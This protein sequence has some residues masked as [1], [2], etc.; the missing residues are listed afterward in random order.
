MGMRVLM[1]CSDVNAAACLTAVVDSSK[2]MSVVRIRTAILTGDI[3]LRYRYACK[4]QTGVLACVCRQLPT[5]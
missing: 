1:Q 3:A 4:Q 2:C 5:I